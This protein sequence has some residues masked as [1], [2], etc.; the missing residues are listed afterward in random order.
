MHI[1]EYNSEKDWL[2]SALALIPNQ[3]NIALSGG[4]TPIPI[5]KLL[6]KSPTYF[7]VDERY[8]PADHKD[9]NQK[10]IKE[11]LAPKH[12]HHFD[13]SLPIEE[14]LKKYAKQL[15][16]QLDFT[17]LGIGNDGHFASIF[18]GPEPQGKVAHTK[19]TEHAVK[20][21]L[22]LTTKTILNSKNILVLLK[23]KPS[24]LDQLRHHTKSPEEYPALRLLKH[25]GLHIHYLG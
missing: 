5:Y 8:V 22:T 19:T 11:T 21:R 1:Q 12:F 16:P 15:P 6:P 24:V 7:Q 18:P 9:S 17:I 13:T 25:P 4:S 20:D 2:S 10:M 23:N 3:G 14:C